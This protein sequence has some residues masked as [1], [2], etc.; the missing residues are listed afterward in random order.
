MP[1]DYEAITRHNERQL[2]LDTA[3][4]KTQVCMYSDST[5]FVYEILQNA[6]DYGATE[7]VFKLSED[8]LLV[9]HNGEPFVEENVK[10]ITYFGKSTSR[11]DLVKTGHFGVGFKSVFA[12]TATPI[13]I[14]GDEHFQIY[15]LYRVRKHPYPDD[16]SRSLT[17]ITLPFN[18]ESEHPDYV[19]DL[20]S[21]KKA[22]SNISTRLT[23]LNMN[24]LLFTRNIREIRWEIDGRSGHYLRE[25]DIDDNARWTTITDG[26]QLLKYLVFS[27]VPQWRNKKHKAVD[28]AFA[29]DEKDQLSPIDDFLYVL[30]ATTQET[31]LK[32]ILNGPYRT[33]PSRE[34]ISEKNNFNVHLIT[35]TC[36]LMKDVLPQ[37][38]KWGLLMT[39]F[40][41]VLPNGNDK[42]RD[43]YA[44]LLDAIVETFHVQELVQT[45][46]NQYASS[47]D[48]LQGPAPLRE[49]IT[50]EELPFFIGRDNACWAKGVQQ[51]SRA[52]HFLRGLDIEQWGWKQLQKTL[53]DKY[54]RHTDADDDAWLAKRTDSWIQKLYI[55]L[56]DAIRKDE[57]TKCFLH[58]CRIIRVLEA[59][60]ENHV[61]GLKAYFPKGRS[62]KDL[63][64][65][66]REI[67]RGKDQQATQ[68]IQDS[69]VLLGVSEIGD[70]ERIDLLL[71]TFYDDAS[72]KI[73]D[74]LHLEHMS[75]FIKWWEKEK[76]ADKFKKYSIFCVAGKDG[77][78]KPAECFLDLPFEDTGIGALF[79]CSEIPLVKRMHPVSK[80]Y[81]E[82]NSFKNFAKDVGVMYA[83]EIREY[84]ATKMQE[85]VFP[86]IGKKTETTIDRDYF[87]NA[88][89]GK[90]VYWH[91]KDSDYYVG[92]L[93]LKMKQIELSIAV[94]KTL[95]RFVE[96]KLSA[97]YRPNNAN[98][99]KEKRAPSFLIN[100]L[101]NCAWIPDK[102]GRFRLPQDVTRES[103][104]PD[105]PFDNQNGWLDAIGFGEN[106]KKASEDYKR[107][108][109]KASSLG[110]PVELVDYLYELPEEERKKELK[111]L[112]AYAKRKDAERK[113]AQRIQQETIP[114]HKALSK[115]FSADSGYT[116]INSRGG[117]GS[118]RNPSHRQDRVSEDIATAI[119]NEGKLG[120]RFSFTLRKKWKGKN[121][122]VRVAL[123]EW[124]GGQCQICRKTFTQLSGEPY[125][126]GLYLVPYTTAEWLDRVGNVLCLC[127][128]HSAM[129]QFGP[130]EVDEE[131]IHQ[132]MHLKVQAD[133]GD[134]HP[135]IRM[136]L[137]G[138]LIK[139]EFAEN[140]LIDLQEMI[141]IAQESVHEQSGQGHLSDQ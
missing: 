138:N 12:F 10:A 35:E 16:F 31:H 44:P 56:A 96:K 89:N 64:Q 125:F 101:K 30:F 121:D 34:T 85:N 123:T 79:G 60:E 1:S 20:M 90:G 51:N 88:L 6:D 41:S 95:C 135:A 92:D 3:S 15:G 5:H 104:H 42:L 113:R 72:A 7:V 77:F 38:R 54:C 109:E 58:C 94:W 14:S 111:E 120:E 137:C 9:E 47:G 103:L 37:L 98:R 22:Y 112:K 80:K 29:I 83:L 62:Y 61:A 116:S 115:A 97:F 127:P 43:F 110:V 40:L 129:F 141:K 105:F 78:R 36:A 74:K 52:D 48:V 107:R 49:V 21:R 118:S 24:T 67:L 17:R 70:E 46:D 55:R 18:H 132:V 13:V 4:R 53:Y 133:G 26:E 102:N 57:C 76:S 68:K 86:V 134:G 126:E 59:D 71:E 91:A 66:K 140:H 73:T 65:I 108:K 45:D 130:K 87:I 100:Q 50:K 69:L 114:Y 117:G 139:I 63:P 99:N 19:E 32:F 131:L 27:R 39:Q 2:G 25:D 11:D 75:T 119:K 82:I 81:K 33:N 122:Q 84:N 136:K 106:T 128:W 124:Y 8:E 23:G 28:I 93:D